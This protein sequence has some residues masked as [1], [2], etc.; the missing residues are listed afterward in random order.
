MHGEVFMTQKPSKPFSFVQVKREEG[1]RIKER[2]RHARVPEGN[3]GKDAVG[4]AF[5]GGGI[6]SA[7]FN[8]GILQALQ[9]CGLLQR[10]DYLSTVSGGGYIGASLTWFMS[11]LGTAFPFGT[12]GAEHEGFACKVL[13]RLRVH[14]SYL[15][16]GDGLTWW[17]LIAAVLAGVMI[18]LAVVLPAFFL[19]MILLQQALPRGGFGFP[20][21]V[22]RLLLAMNLKEPTL[23]VYV[24]LLGIGLI[25]L[26]L[27]VSFLYSLATRIP[28]MHRYEIQRTANKTAGRLLLFGVLCLLIGFLPVVHDFLQLHAQEWISA[29]LSSISLA[30]VASALAA[31]IGR[32]EGNEAKGIRSFLLSV[33]LG[34]IS[35]GIFLWLYHLTLPGKVVS[36]PVMAFAAFLCSCILAVAADIN[37]VSM[38]RFYRNRLL[39]TYMPYKLSR[40]Q[41]MIDERKKE[42]IGSKDSDL[43]MVSDIPQTAAP[44][45]LINTNM[46]TTGSRRPRFRERGGDNFIFTPLYSGSEATGYVPTKDYRGRMTLATAMAVSGAAVNPNTYATRSRPLSFLMTLLNVRLG[47]WIS[48]PAHNGKPRGF[49]WQNPAWYSIFIEMLGRGL[50]EK[51]RYIHLTDGGHFENLGL[52]EL[53]KR[54]CRCIILCDATA[55]PNYQFADLGKAIEMVRV[56]FGATIDLAITELI[57]ANRSDRLSPTACVTGTITYDNGDTADLIY[58]VTTL[59]SGLPEDI[60]TYQ[61]Q[62]PAFPD[63]GTG[64]QFFDEHQF[65][66]YRELGFQIGMR[67]LPDSILANLPP[68]S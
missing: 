19:A 29:A 53:V 25:F 39:E 54:R 21:P 7:T 50:H 27:V 59:I 51:R 18:N 10:I 26:F 46:Q 47:Y 49:L 28:F 58:L 37:H 67:Y 52:Y 43:C 17:A 20:P 66:A 68:R 62:N 40:T 38:H 61:R 32:K 65:E 9:R 36:P 33:G 42:Q 31:L 56:D 14:G 1:E 12:S 63:Q 35:Y 3:P 23:F 24:A 22:E 30:G 48:N 55:D 15:T 2:R 41:P 34:L 44:Y 6:R 16:P 8:L 11:R 13:S 57:P 45:H 5:S 64:D 4:L 60:Y